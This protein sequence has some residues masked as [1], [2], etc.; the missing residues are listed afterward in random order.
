MRA[1]G[2]VL[3]FLGARAADG[4]ECPALAELWSLKHGGIALTADLGRVSGKRLMF[5][6]QEKISGVDLH[7]A[8]T[9]LL[10]FGSD[11][12]QAMQIAVFSNV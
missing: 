11:P 12:S 9:H 5:E 3:F 2:L 7:A 10:Q 8:L 4:S 1:A 6:R